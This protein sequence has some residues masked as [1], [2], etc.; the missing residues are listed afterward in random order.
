MLIYMKNPLKK[1]S[2]VVYIFFN[3]NPLILLILSLINIKKAIKNL[4][5]Y[6]YFL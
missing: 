1:Y 4:Y 5:I 3:I 2:Y 6:I